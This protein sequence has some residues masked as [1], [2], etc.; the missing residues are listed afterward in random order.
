M[1]Q[2]VGDLYNYEAKRALLDQRMAMLCQRRID[3]GNP[4]FQFVKGIHQRLIKD[5]LEK[6]GLPCDFDKVRGELLIVASATP[7]QAHDLFSAVGALT[8]LW[9]LCRCLGRRAN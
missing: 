8:R 5:T 6:Q 9:C 3:T 4:H 1:T 2:V 7:S